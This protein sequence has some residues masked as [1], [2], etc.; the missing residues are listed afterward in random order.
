VKFGGGPQKGAGDGGPSWGSTARP[1]GAVIKTAVALTRS[2]RIG[3]GTNIDVYRATQGGARPGP[4]P[5]PIEE[6]ERSG[7]SKRWSSRR[8]IKKWPNSGTISEMVVTQQQ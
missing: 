2:Q 7:H 5:L 3:G 1:H 8:G 6:G 4:R